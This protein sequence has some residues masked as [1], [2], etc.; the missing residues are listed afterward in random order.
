MI[1]RPPRSTRTDTLVPYTTLFRSLPDAQLALIGC[2]VTTGLGAVL[3]RSDLKPGG[4]LAVIGCG[5]VGLA[6]LQGAR[7]A[8]AEIVIGIDPRA[9]RRAAALRRGGSAGIDPQIGNGVERVRGIG[10]TPLRER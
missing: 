3:N 8:G 9:E 1:R 2:G 5:A 4:S 7:I 10:R 6:A